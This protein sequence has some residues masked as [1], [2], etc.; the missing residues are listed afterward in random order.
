M[1]LFLAVARPDGPA[2]PLSPQSV[3]DRL[4]SVAADRH[5]ARPVC[6]LRDALSEGRAR[7]RAVAV[8]RALLLELHFFDD[9]AGVPVPASGR[10]VHSP[11]SGAS[12]DLSLADGAGIDV[13]FR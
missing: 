7:I 2:Q 8:D 13:S 4:V 9:A 6:G 5:D 1:P 12:G 10:T 3:G 11:A